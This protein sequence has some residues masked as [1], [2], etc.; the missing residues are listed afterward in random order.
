M[1]ILVFI[2]TTYI[3]IGAT[4]LTAL[5]PIAVGYTQEQ[6]ALP[7]A[8]DVEAAQT[9]L[10]E[11]ISAYQEGQ[12]NVQWSKTDPRIRRWHPKQRW[13]S[14]MRKAKKR[15]GRITSV[16]IYAKQPVHAKQLPCTEQGHCY[17]K[18]VPVILF[19]MRT[20]YEKASPSQPEYVVMAKSKEGWKFGGGTFPNRPL[21]E[22]AIILDRKD[23]LRYERFD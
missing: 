12:Y 11:W 10:I 21:G 14:W 19:M 13:R 17:R 7:S 15:N 9:V 2:F 23:E 22:T 8:Q 1:K 16:K 4:E 3:A 6:L 20:Q 5:N 18:D